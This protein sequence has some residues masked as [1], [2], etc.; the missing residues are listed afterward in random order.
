MKFLVG[1]AFTLA[2]PF[3]EIP[4]GETIIVTHTDDGHGRFFF[5]WITNDFEAKVKTMFAMEYTDAPVYLL[6]YEAVFMEFLSHEHFKSS[7][8][9]TDG[10][11]DPDNYGAGLVHRADLMEPSSMFKG[12]GDF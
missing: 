6:E 3:Y 1:H 12:S 7:W 4:A 10:P 9:K 2:K 11:A 5:D 8:V